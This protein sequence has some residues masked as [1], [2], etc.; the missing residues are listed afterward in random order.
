MYCGIDRHRFFSFQG[1]SQCI[2]LGSLS[3]LLCILRDADTF[4]PL[5]PDFGDKSSDLLTGGMTLSLAARLQ[6]FSDKSDTYG[7][8][9]LL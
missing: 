1:F 2:T 7:K 8:N 4:L 5:F 3:W 9:M 6:S